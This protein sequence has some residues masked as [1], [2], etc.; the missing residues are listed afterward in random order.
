[1]LSILDQCGKGGGMIVSALDSGLSHLCSVW[2]GSVCFVL[3]WDTLMGH[4]IF[5]LHPHPYG[6]QIPTA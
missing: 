2:L 4:P 3:E 1:M 6:G 5:Y